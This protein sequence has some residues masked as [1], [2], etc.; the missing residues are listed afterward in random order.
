MDLL[1]ACAAGLSGYPL[2]GISFARMVVRA[3][4]GGSVAA[5]ELVTPDGPGHLRV[6]AVSAS[7]VRLQLSSRYG[8][9]VGVLDNLKAFSP[10]LLWRLARPDQ[11]YFLIR[12][13]A[14]VL[15]M[16]FPIMRSLSRTRYFEIDA[17]SRPAAGGA[18]QPADDTVDDQPSRAAS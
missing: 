18:S 11:P 16:D 7:E 15:R 2:G 1:V 3:K 14:T 17:L 12:A 6:D 9:L 8:I 13:A 5:M 10:T 4:T